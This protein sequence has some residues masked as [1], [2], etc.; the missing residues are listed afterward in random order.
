M[1]DDFAK[2]IAAAY[3]TDGEALELGRAVHDGEVHRDAAVRVPLATLNRHGLI[4]GATGTG[5]TKTLQVMAEQLSAAGVPVFVADVK[6]DVSGLAAPAAPGGP[7]E[8]RMADLRLAFQPASFPVEFLSLGGIGP[9]VPVRANVSDFGPQLLAKVL[10]ANETQESSLALVFH[11][12]DT[13]GLPLVDLSD[14]RALLTFLDS[15]AG[16]AELEGIGG[17]SS[18]TVGVLLRSLVGLE[19][20][21]G[22]EFFGEPQLDVADLMRVASDGRGIVSCLELA[23]VQEKP[24]LWSTALM[25]LVAELF[26]ALPEAGDLPKPKLVFFLDEAHLLFA[27]ATDAFLESVARTVRLIRSKGVGVFFVTQQPTDIPDDVLGQ[28]GARVQHALRAFTPADAKDLRA[29][30]STYPRSEFYDLETLLTSMGIGEAAVTLLSESGVPTPVAH[31]RLVAP[32]SRMAPADDLEGAARSSPLW[33][34]YGERTD[35]QSAREMLAGRLATAGG[36]PEGDGAPAPAQDAPPPLDH[37]PIPESMRGP[38]RRSG[39]RRRAPAPK[40]STP[41]AIGDFLGSR[42]GKALQREIVRGVFGLL[43]KRL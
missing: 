25:W 12:A 11:Y 24:V 16:K 22:T 30:V 20:G 38:R 3:A 34:H 13:K 42:Q 17:L 28:L 2:T 19:T 21:G 36:E 40:T 32:A 18:Q 23:A 26:E 10:G 7:A 31:T 41:E 37:I 39:R 1:P 9:G 5:K 14:L 35:P 27:D 8:K 43:R 33:S 29:T 15:D 4:A 6:G